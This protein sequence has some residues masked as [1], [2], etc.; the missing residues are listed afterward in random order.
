MNKRKILEVEYKSITFI[1]IQINVTMFHCVS[2]FIGFLKWLGKVSEVSSMRSV[3]NLS[4]YYSF[5]IKPHSTH[6]YE[7]TPNI[8]KVM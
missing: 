7:V 8:Y 5:L 4:L 2:L 6:N 1:H 3:L